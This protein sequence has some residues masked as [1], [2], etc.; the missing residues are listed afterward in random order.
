HT[1]NGLLERVKLATTT[2]IEAEQAGLELIKQHCPQGEGTLAGNT[3]HQDRRFL[4]KYM[5]TLESWLHYRQVDVSSLKVLTRAWYPDLPKHS[6]EDKAHTALA[7]I[8]A[9]IEELKY[10]RE[11]VFAARRVSGG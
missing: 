7:D 1:K 2:L 9:S 4:V 5:P 6:K 8:R 10:Y 3:I 11:H